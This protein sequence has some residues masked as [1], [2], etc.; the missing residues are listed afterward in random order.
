MANE[1]SVTVTTG[2]RLHFGLFAF[3]AE[4]GPSFGGAGLMI[5][6]PHVQVRASIAEE[7]SCTGTMADRV[8]SAVQR[9][10][11]VGLLPVAPCCR[12]EEL[13]APP[14]HSGLGSGTQL[15]LATATAVLK[16]FANAA[17]TAIELSQRLARGRRSAIG[18]HGFA[19]GGLLVDAGKSTADEVAPLAARIALPKEWRVLLLLPRKEQGIAGDSEERAF[20]CLPAIP[21]STTNELRDLALD[22]IVPA[23]KAANLPEF[24]A[25]VS[26]FNRLSGD[27]F[28][29]VQGG[30]YSSASAAR[31]IE[32]LAILGA[33]AGQS[34]WGPT[35]FAFAQHESH[36]Q[37]LAD[38]IRRDADADGWRIRIARPLNSG[39]RIETE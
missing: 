33:P 10:V 22:E 36:A 15:T 14:P 6:E 30:P 37:Q 34:S 38:A 18:T 39:A 8:R 23:A 1:R 32:R 28:S 20:A 25:A 19:H 24:A 31:W 7:F 21:A 9:L 17:P 13:A 27:C 26:R 5:A 29:T 2:S 3:D 16:L 11:D 4:T 35:L 12:I